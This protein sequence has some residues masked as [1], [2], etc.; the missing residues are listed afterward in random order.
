MST[1]LPN[2]DTLDLYVEIN[3]DLP[4]THPCLVNDLCSH[5]CTLD[6]VSRQSNGNRCLLTIEGAE[7]VNDRAQIEQVEQPCHDQD[8]YYELLNHD[9][10]SAHVTDVTE[11]GI[12]I[13]GYVCSRSTLVELV[14]N[15][16]AIGEVTVQK[17]SR[18]NAENNPSD[19]RT[20]DFST[21]T[22]LEQKTLRQA[23]KNGYYDQPRAISLEELADQ[24]D[25]S[26]GTV[27]QR[28]QSAERKLVFE[29]TCDSFPG[30][31]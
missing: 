22:T 16:S 19:L 27:S 12:H 14:E 8:C 6:S 28:L 31:T 1:I 2:A 3:L 29:A 21:L 20:I 30:S 23:I 4:N 7:H 25:V 18:F 5:A 24:F 11:S 13:E 10:F 17:L 9:G 26:K 15:L